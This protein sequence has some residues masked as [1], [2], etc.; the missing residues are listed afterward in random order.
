MAKKW[1]GIAVLTAA[2]ATMSFLASCGGGTSSG[3]TG[4]S[5]SST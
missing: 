1:R 2:V 5:D 3:S 4:T